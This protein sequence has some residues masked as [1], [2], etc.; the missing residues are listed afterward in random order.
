MTCL[1]GGS[2]ENLG[3][4]VG[5]EEMEEAIQIKFAWGDNLEFWHSWYPGEAMPNLFYDLQTCDSNHMAL[6]IRDISLEII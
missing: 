5:T 6:V 1:L 3:L 2:N 4:L